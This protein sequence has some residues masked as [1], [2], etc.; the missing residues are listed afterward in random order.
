M[1]FYHGTTETGWKEMQKEGILFGKR[2][3]ETMKC[4]PKACR[5]TWLALKKKDAMQWAKPVLLEVEYNP[6]DENGEKRSDK[7]GSLTNYHP[8]CWQLTCYEPIPIENIKRIEVK[9]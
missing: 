1:K 6:Y 8:D 3:A 7:H 9:E 4:F 5:V 2:D